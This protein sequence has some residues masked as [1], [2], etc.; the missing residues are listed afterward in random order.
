MPVKHGF[1]QQIIALT[2][3]ESLFIFSLKW[4]IS[5]SKNIL[6]LMKICALI[7]NSL[8]CS[9]D[10]VTFS[11]AV[12]TQCLPNMILINRSL[13]SYLWKNDSDCNLNGWFACPTLHFAWLEFALWSSKVCNAALNFWN[14]LLQ[15]TFKKALSTA[16]NFWP[17][18]W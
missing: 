8:F 14:F 10:L 5:M 1:S 6:Y 16:L 3:V 15:S 7:S 9:V 18:S 2:S 13:S 17:F 11:P 4:V 12:N